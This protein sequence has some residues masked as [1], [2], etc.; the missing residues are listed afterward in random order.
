ML[1]NEIYS[2]VN[3]STST[4]PNNVD[5]SYKCNFERLN[6]DTKYN[7]NVIPLLQVL[8]TGKTKPYYL[9]IWS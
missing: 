3:E 2:K 9:R 7:Y 4:T 1:H 8:R 5:D 6:Q